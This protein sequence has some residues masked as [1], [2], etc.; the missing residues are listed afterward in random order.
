MIFDPKLL[1]RRP[2][3]E[4][5]HVLLLALLLHSQSLGVSI[6]KSFSKPALLGTKYI[7]SN[8]HRFK[9]L[10]SALTETENTP[11]VFIQAGLHGDESE[12]VSFAVW[13]MDRIRQ[14]Q[15]PLSALKSNVII[16]VLPVANPDGYKASS[17]NNLKDINLNRNFSVFHGKSVDRKIGKTSFSERET[18]RLKTLFNQQKYDLAIDIHGYVPW[19]VLPTSP[20]AVQGSA[21]HLYSLKKEKRYNQFAEIT[22]RLK[23]SSLDS[24]YKIVTPFELGDGGSFEDWAFWEQGALSLCFEME[25]KVAAQSLDSWKKYE[26][27]LAQLIVDSIKESLI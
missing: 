14:N 26:S 20:K 3:L 6:P 19:L 8:V 1:T 18:A 5:F 13:L 11:K 15:G 27:Y 23:K 4:V 2:R 9:I 24:R 17:R 21:S 12:T 25:S 16:D 10:P 7:E 22:R